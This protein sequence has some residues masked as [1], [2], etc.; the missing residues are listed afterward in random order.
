LICTIVLAIGIRS[1]HAQSHY[2]GQHSGKFAITDQLVPPVY[3]FDL[4]DVRLAES[5][6][7]QNRQ[8]AAA[9]LLSINVNQL[10][11]FRTNVGVY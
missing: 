2:P 10:H 9:W 1:S 11:S 4:Q 7:T 8:R 3:S 5:R 6:F